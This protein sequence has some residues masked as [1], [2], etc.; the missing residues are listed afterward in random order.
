LEDEDEKEQ[1]AKA[2]ADKAPTSVFVDPKLLT[3]KA[4]K[5]GDAGVGTSA[6]PSVK[7]VLMIDCRHSDAAEPERGNRERSRST[8]TSRGCE[9]CSNSTRS[10]Q[11]RL[12]EAEVGPFFPLRF[13]STEPIECRDD[14]VKKAEDKKKKAQKVERRA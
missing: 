9:E 5:K 7:H 12:E 13:L 2:E 6:F 8:S 4:R 3:K 11:E 1:I 14:A 10:Q